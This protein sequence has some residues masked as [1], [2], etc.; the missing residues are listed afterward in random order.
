MSDMSVLA[1]LR[2]GFQ[3]KKIWIG[4]WV[5]GWVEL[6]PIF[7]WIIGFFFNFAKPLTVHEVSTLTATSAVSLEWGSE[8]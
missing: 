2:M 7:V 4:G 1:V 5:G 3:K 6:Y 8:L